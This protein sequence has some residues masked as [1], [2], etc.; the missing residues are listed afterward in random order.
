MQGYQTHIV[1]VGNSQGIRIPK[2]YLS[3]LGTGDV[4]LEAKDN[5]IMIKPMATHPPPRAQWAAI[6]SKMDIEQ[7]EPDLKDWDNTLLDGIEDL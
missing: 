4:V 2:K 3:I 5:M 7:N 6:L 1:K